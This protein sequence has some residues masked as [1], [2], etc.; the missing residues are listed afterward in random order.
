MNNKLLVLFICVFGFFTHNL[1]A[2]EQ[3]I[4]GTI[5][6][7]ENGMP[8]P[9]VSVQEKGTT[10][11]AATDFDGN[12]SIEVGSNATLVFSYVGFAAQEIPVGQQTEINVQLVQDVGA[13][14]EVVVT[15]L[16]IKREKKS[17]GYA[18]QEVQGESLVEARENNLANAFTGKV[19]GL[20]V[21][22]GSNGPASSSKIVLR[23][24]NSLTG[25][26]QPLIVVDGIPM[27]NFTG[28][29]NNDFWNPAPDMGNGLGDLNPENIESMS[30]LKGASAAALYGSR[31]GNGV[32]L[33]TTKSGRAQEGL[34]IT[35]SAS[36]GFETIF[37][38]P[39]I[40]DTFGQGSQGIYSPES[41]LSWGPK[42]EG[43]T[44]EN[45]DGEQTQLS[46]HDNLNNYFDTGVNTTHSL[47]FSQQ[48]N[49]TSVY[50]SITYLN[51]DSKIP[52]STLDRTNLLTRAVTNFGPDDRWTTDFKVQ[53]ISANAKNRP[54]SGVNDSN[55]FYTMYMLP[56][57]LNIEDFSAAANDSGNHYWYLPSGESNALNP[58]WSS[59]Y[60]LNED[61]RDRFLL[62]GS[63][64]YEFN[65][66]LSA[67][68]KAGSDQYTTNTSSR[69]YGGSPLTAT[70]RYSMGKN[71]FMENNFSFL[72]T[73]GQ[74]N[75]F[76][77]FGLSG[78]L[79]GNLMHQKS[80]GISS[81]AGELEVP[82][83]FSLNNGVANPTVDEASS[84][85]KINSLYGTLQLNYGGFWFL[86]LTGRN[87]WSSTLSEENRS[88]FYPSVSTSL[89]VTDFIK[90]STNV[91][92]WIT[93]GKLRASYAE[94][95][96]D[97]DPYQ[98]Y[99][100]YSINKSPNGYT[101]AGRNRV[102]YNPNVVNELIKSWEAGVEGRFFNNRLGF[103]FSWYKTNATNQLLDIPLNP[104]S[105][106]QA[107]KV[108]AGDIENRGFE[109]MLNGRLIDNPDGFSWDMNVN[110]S[111]NE[112][113]VN[114]L[115]EEVDTYPLGVF[116]NLSVL[117][118]AGR[119]YGEIWGTKYQ[120]VED[121]NSPYFG[122][123]ILDADG[124]PLATPDQHRL[125]NQQP[126][127]LLGLTN[128]FSYKGLSLSFLIDGRFGGEIFS[129]TNLSMQRAGTA[130]ATVVNGERNDFVVDGVVDV[131]PEGAATPVYAENTTAVSPQNYWNASANTNLGINEAN[132]Y[133]ATNIRLRNVQLNY[134][135]PKSWIDGLALQGAQIGV[136][137][138]NVWMIDSNMNGIDPESIFA[139]ATNAVGFENASSPTSRSYYFNVTLRF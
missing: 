130:A 27:D 64:N 132:I 138:N 31:A 25:D 3:I 89:V 66:W 34:G 71:T 59:R 109:V 58:Y 139:T 13:L 44:V 29:A 35:Y 70:G 129:G 119:P 99:N 73:A 90:R 110:F 24:N 98:L 18:L 113:I 32:I 28:S 54:F 16:G 105:G 92:S 40:Q 112:N 21:V 9:G 81:N 128:T 46:A 114:E 60:N 11:G 10:N 121:E 84:E 63:I 51:D 53:Y 45:W 56:R 23:G 48:V 41:S 4:S 83:L 74:D 104:L 5:T 126:D 6:D 67:Q 116:D 38:S 134:N 122:E 20:N 43:Q 96:N 87:D 50:S 78:N 1:K 2:Q 97:L 14:D 100:T 47:S 68:I 93:Y 125:G 118:V 137:A 30:V 15:A 7:A 76:G 91:P 69:V 86:D 133:D 42:I 12:Y 82:N 77:E 120:R 107:V 135:L 52:G 108:N 102:L 94:V 88:F 111:K 101:T 19:A 57:S 79:G 26:N 22:R 80:S 131:T 136:S 37:T 65:D 103:D 106:Y 49:N 39:D 115:T 123:I 33:I 117:A 62:N 36:V 124:M 17:L 61:T 127:A 55:A 95:G 75:L 8:L 72:F 85:K